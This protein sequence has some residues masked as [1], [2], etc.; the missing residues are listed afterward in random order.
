MPI[1]AENCGIN[2]L[3]NASTP[4]SSSSLFSVP[5]DFYAMHD[6]KIAVLQN[7]RGQT[8]GNGM[9]TSADG[10]GNSILGEN[11][12]SPSERI[13]TSPDQ[14]TSLINSTNMP[15]QMFHMDAM[16]TNNFN[17]STGHHLSTALS[18][19][20]GNGINSISNASRYVPSGY[21]ASIQIPTSERMIMH[22]EVM[23]INQLILPK[24]SFA[25][26][27]HC[28]NHYKIICAYF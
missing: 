12:S 25:R 22:P 5:A 14:L 4:S 27:M 26:K 21:D 15:P 11:Y 20:N 17:K 1:A 24:C 9:I 3:A 16:N 6:A 28:F 23:L 8:I 7:N 13:I 19:M 18:F 2:N 10:A